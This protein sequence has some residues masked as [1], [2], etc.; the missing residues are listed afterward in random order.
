MSATPKRH[1][2]GWD[3]PVLPR[4]ARW[5]VREMGDLSDVVVALPGARAARRLELHLAREL[6]RGAVPPRLVG[7]G[8]LPDELLLPDRPVAGRLVRTL[9]WREALQALPTARRALL[10]RRPPA[11]ADAGA[12]LAL[13]EEVR[14]LHGELARDGHDFAS[15]APVARGLAGDEEGARW[16]VLA[17]ARAAYAQRLQDAGLQDPHEGR[18]AALAAGRLDRQRRVVLVGVAELNALV[19]GLLEALGERA[20]ILV[21][22]PESLADAFDALGAVL[23]E[24]WSA[25]DIALPP[26]AWLLVDR[27]D[28][29]AEAVTAWI[30]RHA[31]ERRPEEILVGVPDVE[32]VPHLQRRLLEH[33]VRA[34]DARGTLVGRTSPARLL[35][36]LV[37]HLV[38]P[39]FGSFATLL[40]HPDVPD[41]LRRAG[42]ALPEEL[43][44]RL[45]AYQS[46]HLPDALPD[47]WPGDAK[48]AARAATVAAHEALGRLL[49]ELAGPS[50][51][52]AEWARPLAELLSA[53]WGHLELDE[54]RE[55]ERLLAGALAA[56]GDALREL[57]ALPAAAG[58]LPGVEA[59]RLLLRAAAGAR[60]P[61]PAEPGAIELLG[62]LE[63]PLDDAPA[64]AVTGLNEG[65]VPEPV[66]RFALLP[67]GLRRALQL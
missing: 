48:D 64:L 44:A 54:Q 13:A 46:E 22:A 42:T 15:V 1:F 36:V 25:R 39:T 17:E 38:A 29:Q 47:R 60:V 58:A 18:R 8:H 52:A 55:D 56:L 9:L 62:W 67:D 10:F 26:D 5:L 57:A 51:P 6:P 27:P 37:A 53:V 61:P 50:R 16:D 24:A 21:A 49:R 35:E 20:T 14:S 28:E 65:G 59:L 32:V 45:D 12:W 7:F 4:A 63:L 43:L 3:E 23:P 41:A 2:L 33:G 30:A 11:D 31:A 40:R 34:R 66:R 19:R